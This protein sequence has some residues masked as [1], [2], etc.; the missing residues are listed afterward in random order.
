[1]LKFSSLAVL[2]VL[3]WSF[4][5]CGEQ[6]GDGGD[7]TASSDTTSTDA[8]ASSDT[9]STDAT[10]AVSVDDASYSLG[11]LMSGQLKSQLSADQ[12]NFDKIAAGMKDGMNDE[13][14]VDP[15]TANQN[16][17]QYM[18]PL[19]EAK[20][21]EAKTTAEKTQSAYFQEIA[22]KEG[23]QKTESGIYYEVLQEGTGA[24]PTIE[25]KVKVHYTGSLTDGT[26]FD[27]SVERGEPATFPV[28]GVIPG[29]QEIVPMMKVGAKWRIHIPFSLA[30]GERGAGEK[31]PPFSPLVFEMELL[32]IVSNN[33]DAAQPQAAPQ[34]R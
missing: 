23:I 12:L 19:A 34:G 3:V 10:A 17:M 14:K 28:N 31:I 18:Q 20:M 15:Q 27:S 5:S 22:Q 13:A 6:K 11:V 7:A 24:S 29:W 26:V 16:F 30:Y 9:T 8:T 4:A 25:S 1:M 33:A 21:T 32:D 2:L